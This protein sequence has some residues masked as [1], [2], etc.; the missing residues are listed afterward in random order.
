MPT[1]IALPFLP[2]PYLSATSSGGASSGRKATVARGSR[3]GQT[4]SLRASWHCTTACR[5][6]GYSFG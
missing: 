5:G 4:P 3:A 6:N 1:R 2:G